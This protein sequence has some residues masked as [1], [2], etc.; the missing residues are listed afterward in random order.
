MSTDVGF[1][2]DRV[3]VGLELGYALALNKPVVVIRQKPA[4]D[5]EAW[6]KTL[7]FDI[8]TANCY[9]Y[10]RDEMG[11]QALIGKLVARV[12]LALDIQG[13]G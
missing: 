6:K 1:S 4:E 7:P 10:G 13:Q 11:K 9:D 12:G 2:P 3:N 5:V 8:I